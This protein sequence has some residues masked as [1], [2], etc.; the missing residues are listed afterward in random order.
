MK[1]TYVL[2][3]ESRRYA[4]DAVRNASDGMVVVVQEPTRSL[5]QNSF[6]W[7]CVQDISEQ[8]M[9][10]G[11]FYEPDV[12]HQHF[13]KTFL[14]VEFVDMPDGTVMETIKSTTKLTKRQFGDFCEQVLAFAA[15]NDVRL[16]A[17]AA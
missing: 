13:K 15:E 17:R 5:S 10:G 9:I 3:P 8:L 6:Y 14:G 7:P 12:W 11:K 16:Q 2:T 4:L 1:R